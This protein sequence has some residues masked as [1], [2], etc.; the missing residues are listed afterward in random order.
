MKE[1]CNLITGQVIIF[2]YFDFNDVKKQDATNFISSLVAQLCAKRD[3]LPEEVIKLYERHNCGQQT[4]A[5]SD[6]KT[7]LDVLMK[8]FEDVFI[9]I[10]A[11]DECPKNGERVEI[12]PLIPD[13]GT[14]SPNLHLLVTSRPEPDIV[15]FLTPLLTS[16]GIPIWGGQVDSDIKLYIANQLTTNPRLKK[17]PE[18]IKADIEASLCTGANGM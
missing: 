16:P 2:Y 5:I 15:D 17:W 1:Y 13:I 9:I 18:I 14:R 4:A 6:L 10:D 3:E 8:T 7:A 12:L 11:L